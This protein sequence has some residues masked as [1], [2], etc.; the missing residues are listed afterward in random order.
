MSAKASPELLEL[1]RIEHVPH[2][3]ITGDALDAEDVLQ[4]WVIQ[5]VLESEQRWTLERK[6]RQGVG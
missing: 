5:P 3:R 2:L 1:D 4:R 6:H